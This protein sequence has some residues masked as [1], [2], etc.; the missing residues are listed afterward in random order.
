[1]ICHIGGFVIVSRMCG[2]VWILCGCEGP[3]LGY[4]LYEFSIC[5]LFARLQRLP[6]IF[7]L[8]IRM[9]FRYPFL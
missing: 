4:E 7:T 6:N 3:L 5:L 8:L 1:M 2:S 9:L